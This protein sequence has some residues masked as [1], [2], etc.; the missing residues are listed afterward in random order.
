MPA[1]AGSPALTVTDKR[2]ATLRPGTIPR[3]ADTEVDVLVVGLGPG[4]LIACREFARQ[5]F[6]VLGIDRKQELGWP[7]RCAE[8]VSDE[9]LA[10]CGVTP[11]PAWA[12]G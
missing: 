3:A 6:S 11:D 5:G 9:G 10:W 8:G 1:L 12:Y 2:L 7:K 4:G